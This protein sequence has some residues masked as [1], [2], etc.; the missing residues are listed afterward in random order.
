[1][2]SDKLKVTNDNES[3]T[4]LARGLSKLTQILLRYKN[5][6]V[7]VYPGYES[8]EKNVVSF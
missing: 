6:L 8:G 7:P 1:M 5:T 4:N 3:I 2:T